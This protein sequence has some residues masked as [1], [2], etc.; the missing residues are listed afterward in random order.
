MI[1]KR[2]LRDKLSEEEWQADLFRL[3]DFL[4]DLRDKASWKTVRNL[5]IPCMGAIPSLIC[6]MW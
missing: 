2:E 6:A 3:I 4:F 1:L 5:E